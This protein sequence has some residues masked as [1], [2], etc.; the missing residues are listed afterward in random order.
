MCSLRGALVY[1]SIFPTS[2]RINDTLAHCHTT[3]QY[4]GLDSGTFRGDI[5]TETMCLLSKCA[6]SGVGEHLP[7]VIA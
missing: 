4:T 5:E 2:R 6:R 3:P 1:L 7:L